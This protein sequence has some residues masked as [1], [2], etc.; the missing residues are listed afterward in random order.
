MV[1]NSDNLNNILK[2]IGKVKDSLINTPNY[3]T[4]GGGAGSLPIKRCYWKLFHSF[5]LSNVSDQKLS[6]SVYQYISTTPCSIF[7]AKTNS[8]IIMLQFH[9]IRYKIDVCV[10]IVGF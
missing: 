3:D 6:M 1:Q 7:S 5:Q 2:L 9:M 8:S 4:E 10:F